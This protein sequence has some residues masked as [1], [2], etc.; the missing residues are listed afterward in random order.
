MHWANSSGIPLPYISPF[1]HLLHSSSNFN[2]VQKVKFNRQQLALKRIIQEDSNQ[3]GKSLL[4]QHTRRLSADLFK[5]V[6]E[7]VVLVSVSQ[8]LTLIT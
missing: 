2:N 7:C 3:M 4:G 1:I 8:S 5:F 6:V